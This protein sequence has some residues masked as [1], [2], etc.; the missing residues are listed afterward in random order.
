MIN[1][2]PLL[3]NRLKVGALV[4]IKTICYI[5]TTIIE[6]TT[7]QKKDISVI[8]H[9]ISSVNQKNTSL[10]KGVTTV[11]EIIQNK[12]TILN[13]KKIREENQLK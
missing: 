4:A 3:L 7:I 12:N 1:Y 9:Q 10:N 2:T 13:Y 8:G 6:T 5:Q 11:V